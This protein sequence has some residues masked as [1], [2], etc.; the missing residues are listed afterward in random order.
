MR[1]LV[2]GGGRFGRAT[3]EGFAVESKKFSDVVIIDPDPDRVAQSLPPGVRVTGNLSGE[4]PD[5]V[6][7]SASAAP[8][9]DRERL[10]ERLAPIEAF[11][12]LEREYNLPM[13]AGLLPWMRT[14]NWKLLIVE[15]N[16]VHEW[17][18]ALHLLYPERRVV[19]LGTA[20]DS[21]RIRFLAAAMYPDAERLVLT[22][23]KVLGGHGTA[24]GISGDKLPGEVFQ[25]A[26]WMSNMLS[27]AFVK[28]PDAFAKLWWTGVAIRP[29]VRG[30]AGRRT[31]SH[32]VVPLS[33]GGMKAA[34]GVDVSIA[35]LDI[36]PLLPSNLS[37]SE[38]REF[39][40]Y[41]RTMHK[42]G[43]DLARKLAAHG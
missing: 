32:L 2:H 4:S 24:L 21:R 23:L 28:S 1:V 30:L 17:V 31:R 12:D 36:R 16:P 43:I 8:A 10:V 22:K 27:V 3:A 25:V 13:I 7:L 19:G 9:S 37:R 15:T 40:T 39:L 41:L 6:V 35:G 29:L 34:T 14:T 33:F 20:F 18:N 42:V 11:W 38:R 5:I 26:K